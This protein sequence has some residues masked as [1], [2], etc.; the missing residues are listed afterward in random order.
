MEIPEYQDFEETISLT[1][2]A[3]NKAWYPG[4]YS[5]NTEIGEKDG[6]TYFIKDEKTGQGLVMPYVLVD[7]VTD[8][9]G[10]DLEME[11]DTESGKIIRTEIDGVPTDEFIPGVSGFFDRLT[12][13]P[14]GPEPEKIYE[15]SALKYFISDPDLAPN[16][17]VNEEIA[18]P[19]DFQRAGSTARHFY[20]EFLNDLEEVFDHLNREFSQKEFEEVLNSHAK[21][22]D[23]EELE[24]NL[25]EGLETHETFRTESREDSIVGKTLENFERFR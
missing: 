15:A 1:D 6:E 20:S 12:G 25:F 14:F 24:E 19:I 22:A 10:V 17:V 4:D 3:R 13:R 21:E 11:Y 7:T 5:E 2:Y 9:M 8:E 16:I 23:I 18:V